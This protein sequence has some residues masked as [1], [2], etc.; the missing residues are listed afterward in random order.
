[1]LEIAIVSFT[2]FVAT[3][4]PL[5]VGML[6]VA[7]TTRESKNTKYK[8]AWKCFIASNVIFLIFALLGKI[9]LDSLG[10]SLASLK[11]GGGILLLLIG[12]DLVFA[13]Y[14]G[15]T[16]TTPEEKAEALNKK[17]IAIFPLATPLIAGPGSLGAMILLL[18]DQSNNLLSQFIVMLSLFAV[19][20]I[21]L[22]CM[23]LS[24][25]IQKIFGISGMQAISRILGII[26]VA[27]AVEFI[28]GGIKDAGF[29]SA[30]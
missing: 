5:N 7:I 18:T 19:L 15:A 6:F 25:Q 28:F 14:S 10:I 16:S 8:I 9:L 26:L 1:M 20:V 3:I 21:T 2:T 29:V 24:Q 4:A 22:I 12:I 27:L 11:T 23:F 17:D 30:I 13:N